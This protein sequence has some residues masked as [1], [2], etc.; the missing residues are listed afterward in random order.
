MTR[1]NRL[2]I[3]LAV[4][5]LIGLLVASALA[6]HVGPFRP[7]SPGPVIATVNGQPIHLSEA[8]SRMQSLT[9]FHASDEGLPT[10]REWA[11]QI[12]QS[13]VDDQLIRDEATRRGIVVTDQEAAVAVQRVIDLFP[14]VADYE[15]WLASENMSQD[16]VE[17][18]MGMEV[19]NNH[20]YEAI[21]S[22][23]TV[24]EEE[25]RAY[26]EANADDYLEDD[27][28]PRPFRDVR[29][30]VKQDLEQKAQNAAFSAWLQS[31]RESATVIVLEPNWWRDLDEQ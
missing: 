9:S 27:G 12:L 7:K 3:V 16:D 15:E 6:L 19:L 22:D 17:R 30:E 8:G 1:N 4:S 23:V 10:G 5:V 20:V 29:S 2:A 11:D 21:T 18:R 13:L 26:F 31:A 14:S 25:I 28:T 24:G